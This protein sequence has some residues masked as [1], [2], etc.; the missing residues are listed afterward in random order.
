MAGAAVLAAASAASAQTVYAPVQYQYGQYQE[1]YYGGTNPAI[2]S[3]AYVYLPC[4]LQE[5][6]RARRY[7]AAVYPYP[8]PYM[9][10][11]PGTAFVSPYRTTTTITYPVNSFVYSDYLP[12]E[13]VGQFGYTIDDA[14]NEAY[15]HVPRYQTAARTAGVV[16]AYSVPA[17]AA[18]VAA[19]PRMAHPQEKALPLIN[20][21]KTVRGKNVPL[22][23]A[24]MTEAR[25]YD[26][27]AVAAAERSR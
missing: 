21:A 25:R 10:A 13:E 27:A 7:N 24:L 8:S 5:A 3:N 14:R 20:W 15:A 23:N 2:A 9:V 4:Q 17:A 26:P 12:Y 6:A 19:A 1:V 18:P 11:G 16:S 22:Y